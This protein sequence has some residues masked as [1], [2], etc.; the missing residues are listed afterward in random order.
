MAWRGREA[1]W[2]GAWEGRGGSLVAGGWEGNCDQRGSQK[3]GCGEARPGGAGARRTRG[4]AEAW[5]RAE[6][7]GYSLFLT[8]QLHIRPQKGIKTTTERETIF[9]GHV[10]DE[11]LVF[12]LYKELYRR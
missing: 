2:G 9:V 6:R 11:G 1:T 3:A 10:A 12:K 4:A 7:G 8:P 5:E